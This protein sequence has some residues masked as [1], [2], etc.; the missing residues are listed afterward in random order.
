MKQQATESKA[1]IEAQEAEERKLLKIISEAD[2]ERLR[3]KK[4]LDQVGVLRQFLETPNW[5]SRLALID[6]KVDKK[7]RAAWLVDGVNNRGTLSFS[8]SCI[9][10][11]IF[12]ADEGNMVDG[13][14]LKLNLIQIRGL[15]ENS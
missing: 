7:E 9:T 15:L 2:A 1:Y 6:L 14:P 10:A 13:G 12:L 8:S 3:Q 5:F 4:E 11:W